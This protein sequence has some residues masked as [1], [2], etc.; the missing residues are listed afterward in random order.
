MTMEMEYN[1]KLTI[2]FVVLKFSQ[3]GFI[4]YALNCLKIPCTKY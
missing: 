3:E 4:L 1:Q 2:N